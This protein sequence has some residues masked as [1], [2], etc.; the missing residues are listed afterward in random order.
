MH[1]SGNGAFAV[2]VGDWKLIAAHGSGG[3]TRVPKKKG[4]PPGQLYNLAD[5][6]GETKNLYRDQPDVVARLQKVLERYRAAGRSRPK[7]N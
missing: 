4:D 7:A 5:D 1:H 6:P 3:W 2:R